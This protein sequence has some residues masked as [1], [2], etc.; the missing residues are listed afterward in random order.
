MAS[1]FN[2]PVNPSFPLQVDETHRVKTIRFGDGYKQDGPDGLNSH[3]GTISLKWEGLTESEKETIVAFLRARKGIEA[4]RCPFLRTPWNGA[5]FT[6]AEFSQNFSSAGNWEVTAT[7][8][9]DF[10]P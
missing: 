9:Q 5:K 1:V 3:V 7:L 10:A 8:E 4:F 2:P 6:C